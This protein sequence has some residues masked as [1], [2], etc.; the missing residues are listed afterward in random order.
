M[1]SSYGNHDAACCAGNF[2]AMALA[3]A[4][5]DENARAMIDSSLAA[6]RSL[7]DPFTLAL[8]LH[9]T[10]AVAQIRGD[11]ARATANSALCMEMATEHDLAQ[12]KA[13]SMGLAGWCLAENGDLDRGLALATQ[14]IAAMQ[15][16]QS[17]H[18]L[19]YLLGLLADTHLKAGHHAAATTAV[20]DGLAVAEATG[21]RFY[22]AE[23]HRL[24]GEVWARPPHGHKL[25]AEASFRTAIDLATQQGATALA[26]RA[27]ASLRRWS[28]A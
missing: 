4:G 15:A 10:S 5:D 1:A 14:A 12:P 9:F 27:K 3:L 21:E 25:K 18:F 8:T 22:S 17:R 2:G 28:G 26:R 24:Q 16:M 13:W 20:D 19:A 23:L 11:V 7:D 6:A